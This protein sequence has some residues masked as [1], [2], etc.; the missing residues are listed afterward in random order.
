ML[1]S[2]F[3]LGDCMDGM[4][5]IRDASVDLTVT[6]PPYDGL[7]DYKGFTFDSS[8]VIEQLY[9]VTKQGGVVVWIVNDQTINGSET[10]TSFRQALRFIET[11]FCLHDTMIWQKLS[12]FQ[13]SNRYIQQ[14]EYMFVFSK[15]KPKT[16]NLI[17]DRRNIYHGTSIH[18]TE[19]QANGQTK[20][21]STIQKSKEVKEFGA[22]YNVWD[23][24]PEK[25]NQTGHPAVFP[26]RLV[27]DHIRTW[28]NYGDVVLDP[29]A[30][31]GT[32]LIAAKKL[33]RNYIGFEI[34]TEYYISASERLAK[35][36]AQQTLF[37]PE[38]IY[39]PQQQGLEFDE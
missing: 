31:S 23:I 8:V 30:G 16:A 24:P 29:F 39:K 26:E 33:G 37:S 1:P 14:F 2:G 11:G 7:R 28:S 32:T 35:E 20:E 4:R 10:G 25:N 5:E 3:Y 13:H 9:R 17:C 19:R 6:S 36:Q 38:E 27:S 21:L 15:G 18:G 22:R 12:P 34:S